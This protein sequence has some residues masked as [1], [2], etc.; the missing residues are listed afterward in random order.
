MTSLRKIFNYDNTNESK[1][2]DMYKRDELYEN[3]ISAVGCL[4]YKEINKKKKLLLIK[5]DDPNWPRLDDF[6][7]RI[8][9]VD[10]TI[11]D[12]IIRE[13]QEETNHKIEKKNIK[14][15]LES[16]H[17]VPF[18]NKQSKYYCILVKVDDDFFVDTT[19]FGDHEI[20]DNIKRKIAWYDYDECKDNLAFRL[21][22]NQ[23]LTDFLEK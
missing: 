21:L 9:N 23:N 12:A 6:G 14:K 5:Y 7:G 20:T 17:Y 11:E 15:I 22:K 10:N 2:V 19:I 1:I 4:F 16:K 18:Y 8:D 13:M 3:T